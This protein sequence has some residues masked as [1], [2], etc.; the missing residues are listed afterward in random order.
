[1]RC[2]RCQG[3]MVV[4]PIGESPAGWAGQDVG[5]WRCVICGDIIDPVIVAHRVSRTNTPPALSVA[6]LRS[7]ARAK[8]GIRRIR[9]SSPVDRD[10]G[11]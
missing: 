7:L 11:A 3:L 1:M 8:S 2:Q 9:C 6:R 10:S 5:C 4:E